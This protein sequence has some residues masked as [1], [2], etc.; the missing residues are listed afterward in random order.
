MK[1]AWPD[2]VPQESREQG[3]GVEPG[4]LGSIVLRWEPSGQ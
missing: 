1:L 3:Q 2:H 4:L